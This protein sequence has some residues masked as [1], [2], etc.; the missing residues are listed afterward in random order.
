MRA[1]LN[2]FER[3]IEGRFGFLPDQWHISNSMLDFTTLT[4]I[5]DAGAIHL[6]MA[7]VKHVVN[8][9]RS[10]GLNI[11]SAV[12]PECLDDVVSSILSS[13]KESQNVYSII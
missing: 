11:C 7:E 2:E 5:R 9:A 3:G 6:P 4:T 12:I 8:D 1:I 10:H 13:F